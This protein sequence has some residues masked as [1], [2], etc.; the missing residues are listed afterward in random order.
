VL[1]AGCLLMFND[2]DLV[3]GVFPTGTKE[4]LEEIYAIFEWIAA[5]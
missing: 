5:A 2:L 4:F 3:R 1:S